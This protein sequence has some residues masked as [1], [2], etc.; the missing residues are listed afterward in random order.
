M[1]MI[2]CPNCGQPISLLGHQCPFCHIHIAGASGLSKLTRQMGNAPLM[3]ASGLFL[4]A[5]L[6]C[7]VI[8]WKMGMMG[9]G[10]ANTPSQS[11]TSFLQIGQMPSNLIGSNDR[12]EM[13]GSWTGK[14]IDSRGESGDAE[15]T[16]KQEP[17]GT[18][19]GNWNGS[20]I[21]Q[22]K[23]AEDN[24]I[25]WECRQGGRI[26]K[27]SS[28]THENGLLMVSFQSLGQDGDGGAPQTGAAFLF[29]KGE[30]LSVSNTAAFSGIW[31]GFYSAGP[32]S[33]VSMVSLQLDKSGELSGVWNG[34]A[35][36]TKAKLS[37]DYLE[38]ECEQ[39]GTHFRHIGAIYA[40]GKKLV[41]IY[42]TPGGSD[43]NT[44]A[45][46]ALHSKNP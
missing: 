25:L 31:T 34:S 4:L 6:V 21:L 36:I 38:W 42:S 20:S 12:A 37:G 22:G 35:R 16:M 24:L 15:L 17:G 13:S 41:L 5:F 1:Q 8:L 40:E 11:A 23:R 18:V 29:R 7:M 44:H 32:D 27:Y 2:R 3:M 26:W 19:T 33:G 43:T 9:S 14:F 30:E 46:S 39:G 28:K 45:G 10:M